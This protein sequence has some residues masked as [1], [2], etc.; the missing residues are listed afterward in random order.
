MP[1]ANENFKILY[2]SWEWD[3]SADTANGKTSCAAF[4]TYRKK[5]HG[6]PK[7]CQVDPFPLFLDIEATSACNLKCPACVQTYEKWKPLYMPFAMY[8][9]IID[10]A[11]K[12]G[13]Y[14]CK[15]HT[16][17]RGEPLLNR[18]LPAMIDYAKKRGLI[19]VYLNTNGTLADSVKVLELFSAGLDMI[20]F[21]VDGLR[22]Y[23][24]SKRVGA[25]W[26][27]VVVNIKRARQIRD[28]YKFPTRIRVQ[29]VG[30]SDIDMDEYVDFWKPYA[31][32]V[33]VV[34]YKD[35]TTRV[36]NVKSE[37][38]CP[39][40][41]QRMSVLADGTILPC[42]HDDRQLAA[43]GVFPMTTLEDAWHSIYMAKM[44]SLHSRGDAHLV[45]ACDGCY[46]RDCL[47]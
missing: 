43:L 38:S 17:G 11:A 18:K 34:S 21:S 19:D 14:G 22:E 15:Y 4:D 1:K 40:L 7:T 41:Y 16:I 37:W 45:P 20:S 42:N 10:E 8:K 26:N 28:S 30:Y 6:N 25:S 29:T 2:S 35:M 46:L 27:V 32:E 13:C 23:Y 44:R 33:A 3:Y 5:W 24:E 47:I 9:G 39:Q 31:D 12:K 36:M